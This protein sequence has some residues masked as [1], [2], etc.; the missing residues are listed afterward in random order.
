[1][2][3]YLTVE[4]YQSLRLFMIIHEYHSVNEIGYFLN[5]FVGVVDSRFE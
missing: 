4:K 5:T 2:I 3:D 1:M